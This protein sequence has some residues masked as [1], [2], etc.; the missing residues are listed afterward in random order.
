MEPALPAPHSDRAPARD[1]HARP[2]RDLRISVTDRCNLRCT[3]CMPRD[4]F[5]AE[6]QFLDRSACLT[7]EEIARVA[8]LFV[9][10]GVSKVRITGGEPLVRRGLPVLVRMLADIPGVQDLALTTNGLLLPG[11]AP[12]LREAGLHRVTVSLDSLDDAVF[13]EMNGRGVSVRRVLAGIEAA[14]RAGLAPVKIN[15]VV[16]RGVND[17]G[18][19][20]LVGQFRWTGHI[21]RFIEYLDVGTCNGWSR[22]QVVPSHEVLARI[23]DRYPVT[24]VEPAYRGET[25]S[26]YRFL[27][28]G[29]EIGFISSVTEPFCGDCSRAR[30]SADGRLYT[31]LFAVRGTDLRGLL[32]TGTGDEAVRAAILG[33]WG[34]REDRYSELRAEQSSHREGHVEMFR[35][36]G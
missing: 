31:C 16:Q 9:E 7:Y 4:R 2:L 36:G 17:G 12:A 1:L 32:R 20:D 10:C 19:L 29:G 26:R 24:P 27:D 3:Y 6:H 15:V 11:L 28:G 18:L 21:V 23:A 8:R 14:E 34:V 33:A 30:L 13:G 22:R 25:A 35:M 5:G